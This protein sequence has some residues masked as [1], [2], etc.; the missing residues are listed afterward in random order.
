MNLKE[1]VVLKSTEELL[2]RINGREEFTLKKA[3][4]KLLDL[5]K[6]SPSK[7]H[8]LLDQ[9][10]TE[11]F[12]N[13]LTQPQPQRA[14]SF[15][16]PVTSCPKIRISTTNSSKKKNNHCEIEKVTHKESMAM[17]VEI[18]SPAQQPI[19]NGRK[20][21]LRKYAEQELALHECAICISTL[22]KIWVSLNC[23]VLLS[24]CSRDRYWF[25]QAGLQ[26]LL[27]LQMY[28]GLVCDDKLM[29]SLQEGVQHYLSHWS[30]HRKSVG[31]R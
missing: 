16:S 12:S 15:L 29:S 11:P 21:R 3:A 14:F 23:P 5:D 8:E 9:M 10:I 17:E 22:P 18:R 26:A 13:N 25:G 1:K 20:K 27:L 2:L 28:F 30:P 31:K 6:L 19:N 24:V 7:I 4:P